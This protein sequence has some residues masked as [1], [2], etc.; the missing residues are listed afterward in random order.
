MNLRMFT[1]L[2]WSIGDA[3]VVMLCGRGIVV[4]KVRKDDSVMVRKAARRDVVF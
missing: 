4:G 2:L 3:V 1:R